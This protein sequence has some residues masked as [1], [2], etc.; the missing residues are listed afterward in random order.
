[1]NDGVIIIIDTTLSLSRVC[2]VVVLG[3]V[4]PVPRYVTEVR[5]DP[6]IPRGTKIIDSELHAAPSKPHTNRKQASILFV[7]TKNEL[8]TDRSLPI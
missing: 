6:R 2:V 3:A 7:L 5:H 1:M 8:G 4:V